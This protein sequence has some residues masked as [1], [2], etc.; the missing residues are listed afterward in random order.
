MFDSIDPLDHMRARSICA[1]CPM[2]VACIRE[3][4]AVADRYTNADQRGPD[5]T[6]GGLLWRAGDV[7]DLRRWCTQGRAA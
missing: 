5:G 2:V 6:W 7:L 3:A 1:G 4:I